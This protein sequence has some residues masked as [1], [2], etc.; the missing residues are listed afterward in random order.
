[1]DQETMRELFETSDRMVSA[2]DVSFHRYLFEEIDWRDRLICI[3]G[4]R[5]T[6]KT[7][8]MRQRIKEEFGAGSDKA[9]YLSLDDLW[10][11][12]HPLKDA[13]DYLYS[14]GF[15]H[16]FVDEVHHLGK[17]WSLV[18][19]NLYDQ[20]PLMNFV[21]SGSSMLHLE[22]AKGDLSRRQA[23]YELNGMSFRE[24]LSLEGVMS[25]RAV[26]WGELLGEHRRIAAGIVG[27]IRVLQH[28]AAY[29]EHGFYP[30]YRES[31]SQYRERL[32]E[33]VNK[34][35]ES[36]Y[37]AIEQVSQETIRTTKKMLKV[38]A[39]ST[40]QTPN[41]SELYAQ[42]G[43]ERNQGLKML[44]ALDRAGLLALVPGRGVKLSSLSRPEKIYCDNTNLMHALVPR[45]DMGVRRETYFYNQVRKGHDVVFAGV[46]D[47]L[48]DGKF[49]FEVGGKGKRF[50]QI[51]DVP[52]SYVVNDDVENSLGNKIP[53]WLFGFLY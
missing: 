25:H 23:V 50:T 22:S 31:H 39:S 7:T 47:F 27:E 20:F 14:H 13:V 16:V 38:L 26:G 30:F 32:L 35:L 33:T 2:V 28:F 48:V 43:T 36:D 40:P 53:L 9:I 6:G 1:M 51:A 45:I 49:G 4:S 37:P 42:L 18:I 24:Y 19:K 3:K 52:N 34:V 15:T 29:L 5:G 12:E 46:G 10:F 8:L 17:S 21:Y 44:K 11:A 41:M